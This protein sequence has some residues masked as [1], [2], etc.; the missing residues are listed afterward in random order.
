VHAA[1]WKKLFD[2]Y[3][4]QRA[5]DNG[6][7]FIAFDIDADYRRYVDGKTRYD[8]VGAFLESRGIQLPLGDAEDAPGTQTVHAL[9]VPIGPESC[10]ETITENCLREVPISELA[11]R[12]HSAPPASHHNRRSRTWS[13]RD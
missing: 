13:S 4:E 7:A 11:V 12:I 2:G 6:E 10:S 5:A 3:L 1:A 8:G 9:G